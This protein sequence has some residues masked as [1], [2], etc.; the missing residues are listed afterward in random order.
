[1]EK[2]LCYNC[3]HKID[4]GMQVCPFCGSAAKDNLEEHPQ[5]LQC[6]SVIGGRYIIG[7]VLGQGGFGITYAALDYGSGEKVA[8]KEYYPDSLVSRA[9]RGSVMPFRGRDD[10]EYAYGRSMFLNEAKTLAEFNNINGI[11]HVYSYFEEN[12][13][14]YFAMEY[15]DG[16]SLKE[17]I[18]RAGGR[19]SFEEAKRILIPVMDALAQVHAK[20]IIHRDIKPDNIY[21]T[22]KGEIR[23]L[24]FGS[25]RYSMGEKSRSIDVILT[26]GFAPREQYSRHG[27]QGAY[28]DVYALGATFYY[29]ITGRTPQDSIDRL[30]DDLLALPSRL[31]ARVTGAEEDVIMQALSVD[32]QDRYQNMLRFKMA[33]LALPGNAP[34]IPAPPNA[35]VPANTPVPAS[36]PTPANAPVPVSN[37]APANTPA[38]ASTPVPV[39]TPDTVRQ[40]GSAGAKRQAPAA[41]KSREQGRPEDPGTGQPQGP[42]AGGPEAEKESSRFRMAADRTG[43]CS[44][45]RVCGPFARTARRIRQ[46]RISRF[47]N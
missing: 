34:E 6:G 23:I 41:R 26:H 7:R 33:L 38:P 5:A 4:P 11:V 17:Y 28:T 47:E 39:S 10:S 9:A 3:F 20:G 19:I 18:G 44:D 14:A 43:C 30:D 32:A 35:P 27:R 46:K 24:D 42:G 21:I 15:V 25:A 13:T 22:S 40:D 8:I 29:A 16:I 12:N 1:M 37:P 31:G 36:T 2:V 45:H